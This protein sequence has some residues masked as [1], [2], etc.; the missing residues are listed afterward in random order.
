MTWTLRL[1]PARWDEPLVAPRVRRLRIRLIVAALGFSLLL[2][3]ASLYLAA[4]S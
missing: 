3:A 4:G 1:L 2:A